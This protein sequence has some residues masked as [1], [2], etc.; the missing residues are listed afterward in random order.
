MGTVLAVTPSGFVTVRSATSEY[1]PEGSTIRDARGSLEGRV[2]RVFGPVAR[3]YVLV[4]PRRTPNPLEGA[5]LLG[6]EVYRA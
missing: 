4:R 6:S 5:A 2:V 3:P 1:A